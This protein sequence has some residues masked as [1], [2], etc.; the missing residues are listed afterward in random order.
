M[1]NVKERED[2]NK[3]NSSQSKG[4]KKRRRNNGGKPQQGGHSMTR[5]KREEPK[6]DS[7]EPRVNYDNTREDK[8]ERD[9]AKDHNNDVAWYAHNP[10]LLRSAG[11][12]GFSY[13]TGARLPFNNSGMQSVPGVMNFAWKPQFG[14]LT[15]EVVNKAADQIYNF[16][17]HGNSRNTRYTASDMI[18]TVL[19]TSNVFSM[20]AAMI[21]AYGTMNRFSDRNDYTPYALI[22]AMGFEYDDLEEHLSDM[23]FDIN[24]MVA[25]V[26]ALWLPKNL[27]IVA[28]QFWMNTNVYTDA[29]TAKAQYYLYTQSLY[30]RYNERQFNTGT[31]LSPATVNIGTAAVPE[32][33]VF[34]PGLDG[35]QYTWNQWKATFKQMYSALIK[36]EDRGTMLGDILKAYGRDALYSLAE[37]PVGYRVEYVYSQEVLTQFENMTVLPAATYWTGLK[38]DD[39]FQVQSYYSDPNSTIDLLKSEATYPPSEQVLNFHQ[40]ETPTAEQIM[41]ATRMKVAGPVYAHVPVTTTPIWDDSDTSGTAQT[42]SDKR[43]NIPYCTGTE[44]CQAV[45]VWYRGD[46][47]GAGMLDLTST[48]IQMNIATGTFSISEAAYWTAFDWAPWIY[49]TYS[50][51]TNSSGKI[52]QTVKDAI[53]PVPRRLLPKW[54][55]G[56]WDNYTMMTGEDLFKLHVAAVYSELGVPIL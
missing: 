16:V 31:S 47:S 9:M 54:A 3:S 11:S 24:H 5:D 10:E 32:W 44:V 29:P 4:K 23:W 35:R 51:Y 53:D 30:L 14:G 50:A 42:T 56:D 55:F 7:K 13:T 28:R 52:D 2:S 38:Q 41:V 48:G 49:H 6:K 12:Y 46:G 21:R 22:E 15:I 40:Q 18:M 27:P 25:D 1:D 34:E 45:R 20:L 43:V 8:F 37:V 33:V 39:N 17:V 36:A 19:A 26:A